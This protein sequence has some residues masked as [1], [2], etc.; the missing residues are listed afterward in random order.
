M[1]ELKEFVNLNSCEFSKFKPEECLIKEAEQSLNVVFGPQLREYLLTYGYLAYKFIELNG[2][3]S[4]QKLM[5]D[6]CIATKTK[7]KLFK[8]LDGLVLIENQGDGDYYLVNGQDY[9][10]RFCPE[11][12]IYENLNIKL[13]DYIIQRFKCADK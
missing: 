9:I 11:S 6:I 8:E 10:I 2:L 4:N 5:S 13:F 1:E 3:N 7:S 12:N